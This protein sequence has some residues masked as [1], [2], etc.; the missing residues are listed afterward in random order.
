MKKW[1]VLTYVFI[2]FNLVKRTHSFDIHDVVF[3]LFY[4]QTKIFDD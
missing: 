1:T 2:P 4:L 3:T